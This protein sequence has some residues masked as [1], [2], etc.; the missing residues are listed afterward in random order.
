[1]IENRAQNF[2]KEIYSDE[3]KR[4]QHVQSFQVSMHM[5]RKTKRILTENENL[6]NKKRMIKR[7]LE[8]LDKNT[9]KGGGKCYSKVAP[10]QRTDE[11]DAHHEFYELLIF[12][13]ETNNI[14]YDL[15]LFFH[16][17]YIL[18]LK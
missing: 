16:L 1:M 9:M 11:P 17:L 13:L 6:S 10:S 5:L 14:S 18:Q 2:A 15:T 3:Y 8:I 7:M 4:F 12:I